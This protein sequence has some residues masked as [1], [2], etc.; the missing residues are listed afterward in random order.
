M[1]KIQNYI[2]GEFVNPVQGNWIDNYN[3]S[4]GEVYGQIPNST[5]EDVE[6]AYTSAKSAFRQWSNTTLD[7][8]HKILSKIADL[9]E[10]SL[11]KLVEVESK[12]NGKPLN[13]AKAID[14]PRA[15]SNFRFFAN[16]I[17]QFSSEAHESVGLKCSQFY[18]SSTNR[19]CGLYFTLEFTFVFI[20][21]E[22]RSSNRCRKLRGC[23][24]K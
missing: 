5:V 19:R 11:D 17:T 15:S 8:R 21:V 18:A 24:T 2:N 7:E 3:P 20:Y 6:L 4:I 22:N 10:E 14:I 12:D 16:A 1:I 9:I 13:L 23:K